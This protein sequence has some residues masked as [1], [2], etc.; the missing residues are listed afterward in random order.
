MLDWVVV[1]DPHSRDFCQV[2]YVKAFGIV[3]D[4][5][6]EYRDAYGGDDDGKLLANGMHALM[7]FCGDVWPS[8]VETGWLKR[9]DVEGPLT[10]LDMDWTSL[11]GLVRTQNHI[12]VRICHDTEQ[13]DMSDGLREEVWP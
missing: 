12:L 11:L 8:L 1:Q 9:G 4:E 7:W 5:W 13:E 3:G 10:P 2:G 6:P